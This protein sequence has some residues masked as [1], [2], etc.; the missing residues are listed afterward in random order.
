[1][2]IR[3]TD[4][5]SLACLA[6][7]GQVKISNCHEEEGETQ[8]TSLDLDIIQN[9]DNLGYIDLTG[10]DEMKCKETA[11]GVTVRSFFGDV[12]LSQNFCSKIKIA[13]TNNVT[14]IYVG[15]Q[16]RGCPNVK[17]EVECSSQVQN[18]TT[19]TEIFMGDKVDQEYLPLKENCTA[20]VSISKST[21][22][23]EEK[24]SVGHSEK[25]SSQITSAAFRYPRFSDLSVEKYRQKSEFQVKNEQFLEKINGSSPT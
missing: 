10:I 3:S 15:P 20:K 19:N 6:S 24:C 11:V 1:L 9:N 18:Q 2:Y 4:K 22:L 16:F 21:H 8:A 23:E 14:H 13:W 5:G 7:K 17:Y 25:C 12:I